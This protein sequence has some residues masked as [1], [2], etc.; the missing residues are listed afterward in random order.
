VATARRSIGQ[1]V[2]TRHHGD[3]PELGTVY[4]GNDAIA[5]AESEY[6]AVPTRRISVNKRRCAR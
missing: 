2:G 4:R 5:V 6:T 1:I 3:R